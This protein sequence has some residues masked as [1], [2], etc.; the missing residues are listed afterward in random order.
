MYKTGTQPFNWP[1]TENSQSRAGVTSCLSI[2]FNFDWVTFSMSTPGLMWN[3][4]HVCLEELRSMFDEGEQFRNVPTVDSLCQ[5]LGWN[6]SRDI[7]LG[8]QRHKGLC[9]WWNGVIDGRIARQF[10]KQTLIWA[11]LILFYSWLGSKAFQPHPLWRFWAHFSWLFT[12]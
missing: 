7:G 6:N 5:D 2:A 11:R 12:K 8:D 10:C 3:G 4:L 9:S 1:K